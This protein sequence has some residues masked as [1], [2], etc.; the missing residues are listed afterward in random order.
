MRTIRVDTSLIREHAKVRDQL[1]FEDFLQ[2]LAD[3]GWELVALIPQGIYILT[4]HR[5]TK[6]W[7]N[8]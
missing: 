5:K 8:A 7:W 2:G 4:V 1:E 6:R 3:E